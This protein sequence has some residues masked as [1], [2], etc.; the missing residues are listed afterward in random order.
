MQPVG[1]VPLQVASE[2]LPQ[3]V[4]QSPQGVLQSRL[5]CLPQ[6][7]LPLGQLDHQLD[8]FAPGEWAP[9]AGL[10]LTEAGGEITGESLLP[11]PV[12]LE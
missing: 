4:L 12:A 11:D 6:S 5:V 8:P 10:E 1:I 3:A 9:P 7:N 2:I